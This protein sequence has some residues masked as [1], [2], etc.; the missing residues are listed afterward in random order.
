MVNSERMDKSSS[1]KNIEVK[2]ISNQLLEETPH[3]GHR[4]TLKSHNRDT[5]KMSHK[6]AAARVRNGMEIITLAVNNSKKEAIEANNTE[7]Y[8][9]SANSDVSEWQQI[10]PKERR[11][12]KKNA[13][14]TRCMKTNE[15]MP[16][17][18]KQ[19]ILK[20]PERRTAHFSESNSQ[21][22]I[23]NND[24]VTKSFMPLKNNYSNRTDNVDN[25]TGNDSQMS[26][27][28]LNKYGEKHIE[29]RNT[30]NTHVVK[31][32]NENVKETEQI[33]ESEDLSLRCKVPSKYLAINFNAHFKNAGAISKRPQ[34]FKHIEDKS[35]ISVKSK[36]QI[37]YNETKEC[38]LKQMKANKVSKCKRTD[39]VNQILPNKSC[40][41][42]L[43]EINQNE[44]NE[45]REIVLINS[46]PS[47]V[48]ENITSLKENI[49]PKANQSA[50]KLNRSRYRHVFSS[51]VT[52]ERGIRNDRRLNYTNNFNNVY[53]HTQCGSLTKE[54]ESKQMKSFKVSKPKQSDLVKQISPNK[55]CE[56]WVNVSSHNEFNGYLETAQRNP[57][58]YCEI[59]ENRTNLK[60]EI[61]QKEKR[62][63]NRHERNWSYD[64]SGEIETIRNERRLVCTNNNS[65]YQHIA[66]TSLANEVNTVGRFFENPNNT[67]GRAEYENDSVGIDL[68]ST[69][70]TIGHIEDENK[71]LGTDL[72]SLN[73]RILCIE[74]ENET[75]GLDLENT[76]ETFG[77]SENETV[78]IH[79]ESPNDI[80]GAIQYENRAPLW[81]HGL[82]FL[83]TSTLPFQQNIANYMFQPQLCDCLAPEMP[84]EY[85]DNG[86]TSNHAYFNMFPQAT[87]YDQMQ[88]NKSVVNEKN[89]ESSMFACQ[90]SNGFSSPNTNLRCVKCKNSVLE[91]TVRGEKFY[92]RTCPCASLQ[93]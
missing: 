42:S 91:H 67:I 24:S 92:H 22:L 5:E 80:I 20:Y 81:F 78:G 34:T 71:K 4:T 3:E 57:K 17:N 54:Y 38:K 48:K 76:N 41:K 55:S 82:T 14:M 16:Q 79:L 1:G 44:L 19:D 40:E 65:V 85:F 7:R 59:E 23:L 39:S 6:N 46:K 51:D 11:K 58:H 69:N 35:L 47:Q 77:H 89:S 10:K 73:E 93:I 32:L 64:L 18:L 90:N 87:L 75:V 70:D 27:V 49:R 66:Y 26:H 52:E 60:R 56:N 25:N 33:K 88:R 8:L 74:Y 84:S 21:Q 43:N 45:Y 9:Y 29:E 50:G 2:T 13:D 36:G 30:L 63:Y 31:T 37:L 61:L 72:E 83:S 12:N 28:R 86:A 53:Q 62:D 68:E 15:N